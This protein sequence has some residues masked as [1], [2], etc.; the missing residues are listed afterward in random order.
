[1]IM[2]FHQKKDVFAFHLM[3]V[4][5]LLQPTQP[6]KQGV[7]REWMEDLLALGFNFTLIKYT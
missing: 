4:G 5:I 6:W 2:E 1:M 3:Q 7:E